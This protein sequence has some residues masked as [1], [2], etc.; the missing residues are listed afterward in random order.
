MATEHHHYL[1]DDPS[2]PDNPT[3][4]TPEDESWSIGDRQSISFSGSVTQSGSALTLNGTAIEANA[5][6]GVQW[7]L[8]HLAPNDPHHHVGTASPGVWWT[9]GVAAWVSNP[10]A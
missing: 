10:I 4:G 8:G 7:S 6:S 5:F 3:E 1:F 2:D 9:P